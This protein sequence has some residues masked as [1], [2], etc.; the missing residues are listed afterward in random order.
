MNSPQKKDNQA[1]N[2][3]VRRLTL[4]KLPAS[5]QIKSIHKE[6]AI[7]HPKATTTPEITSSADT[8]D[9]AQEELFFYKNWA[10]FADIMQIQNGQTSEDWGNHLLSNLVPFVKGFQAALYLKNVEDEQDGDEEE[11]VESYRITGGYALDLEQMQQVINYGEG[12]IGQVAKSRQKSHIVHSGDENQFKSVATTIEFPVHSIVTLPIIYQEEVYGV[13]EILFYQP[14]E[15][16]YLDFLH[17]INSN[18]GANLCLFLKDE[19][20]NLQ[21][22]YLNHQL[23]QTRNHLIISEEF[24]KIHTNLTESVM[25][26]SNIQAAILPSESSFKKVFNDYFIMYKPKD[27]VSGDFYW[28]AQVI[29]RNKDNRS[30]SRTT[31]LAVVDCTGH[32]VPGAFMSMIGNML[33]NEIVSK[34][35]VTNPAKILKML[36]I[37]IR[38]SLKQSQG[39]NKDGMDVCLCKIVQKDKGEF[40]ITFAGAKRQ[41]YYSENGQLFKKKGTRRS[42][43][44]ESQV[45]AEP[46]TN[47]VL[48]LSAGEKLFLCTDGFKDVASPKRRNFGLRKLETLLQEG[49]RQDMSQHKDLLIEQLQE[50]QQNTAQRDD[51]TLIGIQL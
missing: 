30:T 39:Q 22:Q 29:K 40:K 14:V 20:I 23:Q 5:T 48:E 24:R 10:R 34:K 4:R 50:H 28:L 16:K 33:L 41:L 25:Y 7:N 37:G 38:S 21:N 17:R 31:F 46:F 36:H 13:L 51:I 1:A 44:G 49:I 35:G 15:E 32:G 43:G 47:E 45:N 12:T 8:T 3:S 2:S 18:I 42:I 27:I 26:A 19:Q 9:N 6:T 11:A